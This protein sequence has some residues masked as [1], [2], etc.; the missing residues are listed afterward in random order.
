MNPS[1]YLHAKTLM[2]ANAIMAK[3]PHRP[4]FLM[5]DKIVEIKEDSIVGIKQVTTNEWFFQ[6]HFP[7]NPVFPG[8]LQLEAMGQVGG[9]LALLKM[10]EG[11]WNTYFVRIDAC[12]FKDK[13][14]PGDTMIMMLALMEPIRR[15]IVKMKGSCFVG[16]KLVSEGELTAII[17]KKS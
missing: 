3:L 14:I 7:D 4:P 15:G 10:G 9:V 12:K 16:D 5:V 8:V 6:G 1:D 17:Q 2:D 13:V 11:E